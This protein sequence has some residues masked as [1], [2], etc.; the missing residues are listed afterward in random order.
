MEDF[1]HQCIVY[2]TAQGE[3]LR[4]QKVPTGRILLTLEASYHLI[5]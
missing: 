5:A 4:N 2:Y 1:R 3:W